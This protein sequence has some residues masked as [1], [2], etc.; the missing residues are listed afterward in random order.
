MVASFICLLLLNFSKAQAKDVWIHAIGIDENVHT[1][2]R[3][4]F[5]RTGQNFES[6]CANSSKQPECHLFV[7]DDKSLVP[8]GWPIELEI[9]Q[10]KGPA[11]SGT[12]KTLIQQSLAKAGKGD[13]VIISLLNHGAPVAGKSSS[14]VW[15]SSKDYICDD[16]LKELLKNKPPGVKVLVNADACFTGGFANL[17]SSEICVTTASDSFNFGTGVTHDLWNAVKNRHLKKLSDI[18]EPV[19]N[20]SGTQLLLASQ[21]AISQRCQAA[22]QKLD[23]SVTTVSFLLSFSEGYSE[24][25]CSD[26]NYNSAKISALAKEV[27][28]AIERLSPQL[29]KDLKLPKIVCDARTRLASADAAIK[30][31]VAEIVKV[32]EARQKTF[33]EV[34]SLSKE[35]EARSGSLS[36]AEY[37]EFGDSVALNIEPDWTKFDSSRAVLA[38]A[39]WSDYKKLMAK[40]DQIKGTPPELEAFKERGYYRDLLTVQSCLFEPAPTSPEEQPSAHLAASLK[41]FRE[42]QASFPQRQFSE[43]DVEE[44]RQCESSIQF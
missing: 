43:R 34:L 14:C 31:A 7:N 15:L 22:R 20:E 8:G 33:Q 29:C 36:E 5:Y 18:E 30:R 27:I 4:D 17:A 10:N 41:Y 25:S 3:A 37:K 40:L 19:Y 16:D 23:Q 13:T 11:R 1:Q 28:A 39:L 9:K 2:N 38:K 21:L 6:V 24:D 44:A 32:G 35:S 26:G 12:L 42:V